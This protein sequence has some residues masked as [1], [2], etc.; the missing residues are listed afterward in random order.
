MELYDKIYLILIGKNIPKE[1]YMELNNINKT[2]HTIKNKINKI[3]SAYYTDEIKKL[4]LKKYEFI[5]DNTAFEFYLKNKNQNN[6][7][8]LH[9]L[10]GYQ[11]YSV[12]DAIFDYCFEMKV[13]TFSLITGNGNVVKCKTIKYLQYFNVS[14]KIINNGL[15]EINKY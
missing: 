15:L 10:F 7:F 9:G 8:D 6:Y 4:E 2:I 3:N 12:L 14:F 5:D 1:K 13:K 11:V